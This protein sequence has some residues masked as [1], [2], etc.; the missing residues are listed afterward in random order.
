[1]RAQEIPEKER[2][3]VRERE[4]ERERAHGTRETAANMLVCVLVRGCACVST[5]SAGGFGEGGQ[6]GRQGREV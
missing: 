3:R 2:E 4:R 5:Y 6:G 1:M